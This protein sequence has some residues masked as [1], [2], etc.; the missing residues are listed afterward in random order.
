MVSINGLYEFLNNDYFLVS[1]CHVATNTAL[2]TV[3]R[4]CRSRI[5][6]HVIENEGY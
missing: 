3:C 4:H 5:N 6:G 2:L 1:D